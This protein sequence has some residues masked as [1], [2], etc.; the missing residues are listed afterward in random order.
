[1]NDLPARPAATDRNSHYTGPN[2]GRATAPARQGYHRT[3][4]PDR[5]GAVRILAQYLEP[6]TNTVLMDETFHTEIADGPN[7]GA[8]FF[9]VVE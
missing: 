2:R 7:K 8:A 9:S 5:P 6:G 4:R 3:D 1:M